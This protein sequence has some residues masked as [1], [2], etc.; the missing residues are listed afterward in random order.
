M[1]RLLLVVG[2]LVLLAAAALGA[3]VWSMNFG[4]ERIRDGAPRTPPAREQVARGAYLARAGNCMLCHTERGG[5]A[6]AGGRPLETPFGTVYA[7][8]ITPDAE[9]G[10]GTWSAAHFRRALHEGR[11]RDGRLLYP[12]FPYTHMTRVTEPDADALFDYLRSLP[13]VSRPNRQHRLRWPYSTQ[14]AL[15]VWRT[16]YFR[17]EQQEENPSRPAEWN[18]G[19]YLVQGLGHCGACHAARDAFG[20]QRDSMDLSGGLIPMQNWYAPSLASPT[21]AGVAD[22]SIDAIVQLLAT[23][24][25][26]RGTVLGPMAEVVLHSTQYL[27]PADLRA[28]AVFLKGLPQTPTDTDPREVPRAAASVLERGGKLYE[29]HC[30]A[31]HGDQGQGVPGAY[32]PLAGN[33]AV[34]LANTSNLVQVI[35]HG[36]FPPATRGQPR[37]FGMPPFATV[38]SDA[39]VAA[40]I[41][42]VRSSWNN[43]AAPV[44]ELS[45]SQQ[46]SSTRE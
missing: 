21:E 25:S 24:A 8:N 9:T 26:P 29:R 2:V 46:R 30:A 10:I 39:D 31:C 36:G 23:G 20:G 42:Y 32:P 3:L 15:A 41:T 45:V 16:L 27:E 7:S 5:A 34:M 17:P 37:P 12:V 1:K 6:Y 19:A 11:S 14:A 33:R 40:V 44:S 35:L 13:A 43:R 22:W 28:M 4:G 18:R 38:M